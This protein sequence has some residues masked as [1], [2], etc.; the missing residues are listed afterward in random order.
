MEKAF[1]NLER[2][3]Q[4]TSMAAEGEPGEW[5]ADD[6]AA[7]AGG[8]GGPPGKPGA[9]AGR[10][11]AVLARVVPERPPPGWPRVGGSLEF[12]AVVL[13]YAPALDP[14]LRGLSLTVGPLER[15]GIAGRTGAGKSSIIAALFRLVELAAGSVVLDRVDLARLARHPTFRRR[16]GPSQRLRSPHSGSLSRPPRPPV[17]L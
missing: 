9:G 8:G 13:R 7:E 10:A 4:F 17:F 2:V 6:A 16:V 1:T 11:G 14:A 12:R 3:F 15:L 5:A